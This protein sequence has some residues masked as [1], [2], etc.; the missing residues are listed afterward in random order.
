MTATFTA[1]IRRTGDLKSYGVDI[2]ENVHAQLISSTARRMALRSCQL[3]LAT[4]STRGNLVANR[5]NADIRRLSKID[6]I[7]PKRA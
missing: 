7:D 6:A 5:E 1:G 2:P 4:N 3:H